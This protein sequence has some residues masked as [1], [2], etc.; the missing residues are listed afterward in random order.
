MTRLHR[1]LGGDELAW[2]VAR[3]RKRMERGEPL[4]IAVTLTNATE[5]QRQA[6]HRLLGR[7]PRPGRALTVSLPAVDELLRRS[8]AHPGGLGSAVLELTGPLPAPIDLETLWARAFEALDDP[9]LAEW[10]L[11]LRMSGQVKRLAPT[12]QDATDLFTTLNVVV[13]NL[14]SPGEPIG[15]FAARMTGDAHALD[16]DRPLATLALR[17]ARALSGLPDGSGAEWRREVWASVGLMRD[18]LSTTVITLGFSGHQGLEAWL[19]QPVHLTL[20]QLVRDPPRLAALDVFVCENP[21]V[22]A[23]AADHLGRS[24]PPLVCTSGQPSAAVM[25]LLRLIVSARGTLHYHGD[26]DWGGI[27]IANVLHDRVPFTPWRFD[28][29]SYLA[30]GEVGRPLTGTPVEARWDAA[31]APAMSHKSRRIEE[32]LVLDDLLSDLEA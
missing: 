29:A 31:L 22:V 19:G 26:F 17:A 11:S 7:A 16:D 6:V 23:T 18:E 30:A 10:A 9:R 15:R 12:P 2:F 14:P 3:V 5:A 8:G 21:V 24:C 4:D 28:T 27:R 32:E 20:R 13:T 25:H 1:L